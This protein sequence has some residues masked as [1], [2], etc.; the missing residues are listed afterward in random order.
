[1]LL[2]L[3]AVSFVIM[4][5]PQAFAHSHVETGTEQCVALPNSYHSSD[6]DAHP[7]ASYRGY[8]GFGIGTAQGGEVGPFGYPPLP[9]PHE[10]FATVGANG[11][12][13]G[14]SCRGTEINPFPHAEH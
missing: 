12:M 8:S 7:A 13:D 3:L 14:G 9:G 1:M 10:E 11:A 4:A 5:L 6:P 2:C